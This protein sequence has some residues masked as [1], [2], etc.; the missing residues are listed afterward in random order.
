MGFPV[1]FEFS[2]VEIYQKIIEK[3]NFSD[4]WEK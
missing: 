2:G 1:Y 3:V 4:N